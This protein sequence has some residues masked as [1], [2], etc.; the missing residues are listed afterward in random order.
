MIC[1]YEGCWDR[2]KYCIEWWGLNQYGEN[3]IVADECYACSNPSHLIELSQHKAYGGYPDEIHSV[4]NYEVK[5]KLLSLVKK[6]I[7]GELAPE[8]IDN[9]VLI[10]DPPKEQLSF[11]SEH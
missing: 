5:P 10:A 3:P 11:I 4:E 1:D 6:A 7:D 9:L 2:A 8:S